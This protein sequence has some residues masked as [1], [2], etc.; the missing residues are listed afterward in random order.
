VRSKPFND[1]ET[2]YPVC[3]RCANPNQLISPDERCSACFHPFT[4]SSISFENLPLVEF[5]LDKG[6][7]HRKF[8]ELLS[9]KQDGD[10]TG[11]RK[12]E[13]ATETLYG[14]QQTLTLHQHNSDAD[15]TPFIDK[16][17]QVC[18]MQVASQDYIPIV[19]NET[20][21][22]SM[23]TDEVRIICEIL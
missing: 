9:T 22:R 13:D 16:M 11:R 14:N 21:V 7:T 15:S 23:N 2:L 20:I 4:R 3:D 19:V 5:K 10:A 18:E 6:M 1:R 8:M 12:H 17:N